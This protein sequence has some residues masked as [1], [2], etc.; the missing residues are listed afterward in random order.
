MGEYSRIGNEILNAQA[1]LDLISK[2]FSCHGFSSCLKESSDEFSV[3]TTVI[4]VSFPLKM[5]YHKS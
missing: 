1:A 3:Q 4:L 2:A 5:L